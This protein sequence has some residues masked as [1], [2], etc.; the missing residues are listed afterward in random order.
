MLSLPFLRLV[1][2]IRSFLTSLTRWLWP[3]RVPT[4]GNIGDSMSQTIP[5]VGTSG[6]TYASDI[7]LFLTEVKN[8]LEALVP[9]SS[10][11]P[12][13]L[14]LGGYTI[15][16][17]L[18]VNL[19]DSTGV[20]APSSSLYQIG[21]DLYWMNSGGAVKLTSGTTLNTSLLGG[22]TGDYGGA[23]PAQFRFVDADQEY[24]AYDDYSGGA[25]ARVWARNFD[26]AAGATSAV[27]AR[28]AFGGSVSQ[29][30]TLPTAA[31]A[32]AAYLQM[33]TSGNITASNDLSRTTLIPAAA[34][35]EAFTVSTAHK[36]HE[37]AWYLGNSTNAI[38]YPIVID[39]GRTVSTFT[40]KISKQSDATNTITAVL[41]SS[42]GISTFSTMTGFTA[43]NAANNPG[44]VSLT[45]SSPTPFVTAAGNQYAVI[46][47]QSSASPSAIDN[48]GGLTVTHT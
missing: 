7:N 41:G 45:P 5:A 40:L 33:D 37:N 13:N 4:V 29:T 19:Y 1:K 14:D 20:T 15:S 42:N 21:S 2:F 9:R 35:T 10:L 36:Q 48:I 22:I 34:S 27:R 44:V 16:N 39:V 12:G 31:P 38:V 46:V 32:A 11:A 8:R 30:Y 25:W 6:T 18:S 23:N 47:T 43:S 3:N 17:A 28:L 24:Y 26:I